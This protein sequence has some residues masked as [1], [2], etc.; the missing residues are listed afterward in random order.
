MRRLRS[1]S[2]SI[3]IALCLSAVASD[4]ALAEQPEDQPTACEEIFADGCPSHASGGRPEFGPQVVGNPTDVV[5]VLR[6]GL[7]STTFRSDGTVATEMAS[8]D[9]GEARITASVGDFHVV[10][11]STDKQIAAASAGQVVSV[12]FNGA[13]DVRVDGLV[14]GSFTGPI[15]FTAG[16]PTNTFKVPSIRRSVWV[17]PAYTMRVLDVPDYWG[18]IEVARGALTTAGTVN[19]VNLVPLEPYVR[20]VVVNES[21]ASFHVEAL[22]AQAAAARG[23]ALSNNNNATKFA[24]RPFGLDDSTSSQVYRGHGSEHPNGNVAADGTIGLVATYASRII[25]TLYSSSMGG[26]TENNEWIFNSPST[27]W[28]GTNAEPYL[29]GIYDGAGAAPDL[30]TEDGIAAFWSAQQPQ[31]FDSCPR[32]NNRFARWQIPIPA[33]TIKARVTGA[34]AGRIVMLSGNTSGPLTNVQITQRMA[35]SKRAGVVTLTF[36]TG[37]GEVRGWDNI[38]RVVGASAV[39]QT[40]ACTSVPPPTIPANFVLNNPSV[41]VPQFSGATLT[42]IVSIGG[43]WGHNVGMSQFGAHG[44][45]LAGQSFIQILQAYYTGVDIA[46]Y[47]IDIT[48]AAGSGPRVMRQTFTAPNGLGM[49]RI[50]ASG[51]MQGLTVHVNDRCDLRFTSEQLAAPLIETDVSSCL[52]SGTNVVQYN[53]AG[54]NGGATVLV[55][56]R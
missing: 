16:D 9:H 34:S 49:L 36:T 47:P 44:R 21:I 19:V 37:I 24:G 32:V 3:A 53:P 20:G 17:Q 45:G 55:V 12:V 33:A 39:S 56:V 6:V 41:I 48:P 51:A 22:K 29:R 25:Q 14:V 15:R 27:Q 31:T 8:L 13:Y 4:A 10:D 28:P 46:S 18:E 30:S 50:A 40:Q 26:H 43:G 42:G 5:T 2:V 54:T 35:A 38:R 52:V 11:L 23:Y 7:R 1:F